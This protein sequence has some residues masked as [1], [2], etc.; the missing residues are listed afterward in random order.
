MRIRRNPLLPTMVAAAVFVSSAAYAQ[1]T[2]TT[3]TGASSEP[4]AAASTTSAT[5]A[6]KLEPGDQLVYQTKGTVAMNGASAEHHQQEDV[7]LLT[8]LTVLQKKD[9]TAII[10]A[11][12]TAN[13][14]TT[15]GTTARPGPRFT[16][17]MPLT[18]STGLEEFEKEG[19][20]GAAF[21]TFSVETLFGELAREGK[22][23][24]TM[25]LPITNSPAEGEAN[26]SRQGADLKTV[27]VIKQENAPVLSRE[28]I[29]SGDNNLTKSVNTS[30]TL[31]L[32]ARNSPI[33]FSIQ[34]KTELVKS[35]KV[36]AQQLE[37]LKKDIEMALPI[38]TKLRSLSS[39]SPEEIKSMLEKVNDYLAKFPNGEFS[40]L[41]DSLKGQLSSVVARTANWEKIKEGQPAPDFSATT[42]DNKP[43]K[44]SDYKGKVVLLDF[45]ATWCGPCLMELPNVKKLYEA[46]K[47][48][49]FDIIGISADE[50]VADLKKL[51]E[52]E[53]IQ[54][55][56]IFDGGDKSDTIQEQYG[57]MKYPTT[58]LVDKDGK[59]SA[60]D[61]RGEELDKAVEKLLGSK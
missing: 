3:I 60:V 10:Y 15:A 20:S 14:E 5:A 30:V 56:Q 34:D 41:F 31:S 54:W 43:V 57:V 17:Q 61:L 58:V 38:A 40:F 39:D 11:A 33:T 37:Q 32:S 48:K 59:I 50:D 28:Q 1:D 6:Y 49:G 8:S 27:T 4:A 35:D 9:N 26:T 29:F 51:V 19:L 25:P 47:D 16:F 7:D 21:P 44:L 36:P 53:N 2:T 45:W 42:I 12:M 18:G 52:Q 22:T 24:V 13:E 55:P 46:N 23:S